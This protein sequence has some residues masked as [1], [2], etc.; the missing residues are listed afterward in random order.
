MF[1]NAYRKIPV[2][3]EYGAQA[4]MAN[5]RLGNWKVAQQVCTFDVGLPI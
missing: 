4:F 2:Q 3:D 5:V 1:D